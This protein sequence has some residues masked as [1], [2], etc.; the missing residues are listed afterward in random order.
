MDTMSNDMYQIFRKPAVLETFLDVV[1]CVVPIWL[2]V[3]I[4]LIVGWSWKPKW[5]GLICL[6]MRSKLRFAWTAPP[7]FGARRLWFALTAL[8]AFP[9]LRKLWSNF[10]ESKSKEDDTT[11]P[12]TPSMDQTLEERTTLLGKDQAVV[13]HEDLE[14]LCYMLKVKD[15]GSAW[16]PIMDR[17]TS[18]MNYQ[19]W[20]HEPETGPTEYCSRT[21]IE[22]VTP[23]LMRDFFWDDDFRPKWDDMLTYFK[24][25]E[26]CP[27]TGTMIVHWIRKVR[28]AWL[29][30]V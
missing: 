26:E 11:M 20:R 9:V 8:S 17:K 10:N 29:Y 2:A 6:G 4:G 21:V 22:D 16:Q 28:Y 25:L 13:T 5:A 12:E 30:Q 15:G 7:G 3:M 1:M 14:N 23:E 27:L 19:A 18:T 24:T